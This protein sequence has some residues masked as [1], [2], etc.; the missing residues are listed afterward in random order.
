MSLF[1]NFEEKATI[2]GDSETLFLGE[3]VWL[4]YSGLPGQ[5]YQPIIA[6]SY[7]LSSNL[8]SINLYKM[9]DQS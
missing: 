6:A 9:L 3:Y 5:S 2:Y 7:F 4:A 1:Q 8:R